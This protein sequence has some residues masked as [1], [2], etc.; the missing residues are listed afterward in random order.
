MITST[1]TQVAHALRKAAVRAT[2]A[3]S[4]HNTQPWRIVLTPGS[5]HLIADRTR[6]LTVLDPTS[7]QLLISCGCALLNARVSLE[8]S[9]YE[10]EV[11]RFPDPSAPDLLA[12]LTISSPPQMPFGLGYLDPLIQLRATNR[13]R[14]TDDP[15]DDGVIATLVAAAASEGALL[16]ELKQVEHR[17][18][19]ARLTQQADREQNGDPA[20]RA[21]MRAWTTADNER[22]DGVRALVVPRVGAGSH[23]DIPIRDFDTQG[24]GYLPME[25]DS[26]VRQCILV[27]AGDEETPIAWLRA[28]EALENLW[29]E[30]VRHGYAMSLFTQPIEVPWTREALREQLQTQAYPDVVLRIGRAPRTPSS[31]RRSLVDVVT[32]TM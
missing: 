5:M 19:V 6:Q 26:S 8:Q 27:L 13:R 16:I 9:G 25:T 28:G 10:V 11:D 21:E 15:I 22:L 23:D 7:R 14:F 29:L 1:E 3:P 2:A 32:V 18:A 24:V 30:A 17:L 20:Y 12:T 31:R 4:V